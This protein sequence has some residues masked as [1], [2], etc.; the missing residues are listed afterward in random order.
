MIEP[1][2]TPHWTDSSQ[3]GLDSSQN[4]SRCEGLG[5]VVIGT[6]DEATHAVVDTASRGKHQDRHARLLAGQPCYR[7]PIELRQHEIQ[8]DKVGLVVADCEQGASAVTS[9]EH[10]VSS[11]FEIRT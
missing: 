3:D 5:H 11:P 2:R 6:F 7:H 10:V 9:G 8:N 4:L 1:S